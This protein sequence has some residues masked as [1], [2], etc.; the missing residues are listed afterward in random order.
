[1]RFHAQGMHRTPLNQDY[2]FTVLPKIQ[3]TIKKIDQ[4]TPIQGIGYLHQS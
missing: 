2:I 4:Q 1:M 3:E